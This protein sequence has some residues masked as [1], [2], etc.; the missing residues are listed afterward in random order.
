[1]CWNE[2][3]IWVPGAHCLV[4]RENSDILAT[5]LSQIYAWSKQQWKMQYPLTNNSTVEK[6]AIKKA[7]INEDHVKNH[8]LCTVHSERTLGCNFCSSEDRASYEYLQHAMKVISE[9]ECI[10]LCE[11]AIENPSSQKKQEYIRKEWLET[12]QSWAMFTWQHSQI[13]LQA[14]SSNGCEAWYGW[15]KNGLGLKKDETS[16]HEIYACVRTVHDCAHQVDNNTLMAEL[17]SKTQHT[18]L[19]RTYPSLRLFPFAIQKIIATKESKV[20]ICIEQAMPVPIQEKNNTDGIYICHCLFS[21]CYQLPC[22]H[23]FH[24]NHN[25]HHDECILTT[26]VWEKYF[27]L[28]G[29]GGLEMYEGVT[30]NAPIAPS[31]APDAGKTLWVLGL[32]EVTK[33]VQSIFY[34]LE[35]VDPQQ[36]S[37][38]VQSIEQ[39]IATIL[40]VKKCIKKRVEKHV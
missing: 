19:I 12:R 16:Q 6:A 35:D 30:A 14:T 7:F 9:E 39:L 34:N 23:I 32:A 28:F 1:M 22:P 10:C 18:S 21:R 11:N 3:G 24:M 27:E 8:L 33:H 26:V 29:V 36:S 31:L 38:F 17:A 2:Y 37:E 40:N 15:L 20:N 4:K 5:A 13:R 25:S